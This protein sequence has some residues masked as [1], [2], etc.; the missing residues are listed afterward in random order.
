MGHESPTEPPELE[1]NKWYKISSNGYWDGTAKTGCDQILLG[2]NT[3]CL[4]GWWIKDWFVV[5]GECENIW[6]SILCWTDI[7]EKVTSIEGPYNNEAACLL[8]L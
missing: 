5:F 2:N 8:D 3:V 7:A 4:P 1:D 6:G